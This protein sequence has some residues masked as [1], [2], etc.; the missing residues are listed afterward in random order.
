MRELLMN[1]MQDRKFKPFVK[2]VNPDEVT[3]YYSIVKEPMCLE[4][5]LYK[6]DEHKYPTV[7]H[8]IVDIQRIV[9]NARLYNPKDDKLH[10]VS[11]AEAMADLVTCII[12]EQFDEDLVK[13][14]ANITQRRLQEGI[15][16]FDCWF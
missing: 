10:L 3:D 14:C 9:S 15:Y 4:Q 1:L 11:K 8:F 13:A 2:P 12:D 5:M 6:L 16:V 7:D